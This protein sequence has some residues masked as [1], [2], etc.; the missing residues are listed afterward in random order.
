MPKA[1][2]ALPAE[3]KDDM[4]RVKKPQVW[5]YFSIPIY[6][7]TASGDFVLLKEPGEYLRD[8]L[9]SE[10]ELPED[11]FV[12]KKDKADAIPEVQTAL[13]AE[14]EKVMTGQDIERA[15]DLIA[16]IVD[17]TFSEPRAANMV[18]LKNT[19]KT[20]MSGYAGRKEALRR[21]ALMGSKD[22]SIVIHAV[23]VSAL[24]LGYC[25]HRD[26]DQEKSADLGL[27]GLLHDVG[28]LFV[29]GEIL[30]AQRKLTPEEFAKVR[31]HPLLGH[32]FLQGVQ[33]PPEVMEACLQHHE[34]IDGG[35]YPKGSALPSFAGQLV[36]II[37]C[38]EALTSDER[39]YREALDPLPTLE[40]LKK[41]MLDGRFEKQLFKDFAYSLV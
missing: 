6:W 24:V 2:K 3:R 26:M 4:A 28:K 25:A 27:A 34:R 12:L 31:E 19:V 9:G 13:N 8:R 1:S 35:G 37:D 10:V 14:L 36:G 29:D 41:E 33:F 17:E 16:D 21:L 38:Y 11:L 23:N 40:I 22:Y 15:K 39:H 7:R 18:P 5:C 20:V 30:T 32:K